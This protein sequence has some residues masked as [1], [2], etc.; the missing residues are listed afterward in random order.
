M[1]KI[2]HQNGSLKLNESSE[3][4][5]DSFYQQIHSS[6]IRLFNS[7][8]Q[9]LQKYEILLLFIFFQISPKMHT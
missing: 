4:S 7:A 5:R 8:Y 1:N 9:F 2:P 6:L 3:N